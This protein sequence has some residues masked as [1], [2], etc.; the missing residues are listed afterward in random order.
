MF[1]IKNLHAFRSERLQ[2]IVPPPF[3]PCLSVQKRVQLSTFIE[4][5]GKIGLYQVMSNI[6]GD[7]EGDLIIHGPDKTT[8]DK[9]LTDLLQ[10][11]LGKNIVLH[12]KNVLS[13][14]LVLSVLDS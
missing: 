11:L 12:P 13:V 5:S 6:V 14:C 4:L 8:H 2:T 9:Q 7:L 10:R 1:A 3:V